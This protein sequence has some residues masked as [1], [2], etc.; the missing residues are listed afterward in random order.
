MLAIIRTK[1]KPQKCGFSKAMRLAFSNKSLYMI[2]S[3]R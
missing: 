3:L 1:E 2:V